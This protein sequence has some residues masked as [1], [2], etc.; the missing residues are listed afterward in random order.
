MEAINIFKNRRSCKSFKEEQ[1]KDEE[2]NLI[3]EAG[4][5]A[6]T[7]KDRQSPLIV[8]TQDKNII[9]KL[10]QENAKIMGV[11]NIDPFY[12][13]PTLVIVFYDSECSTGFEDACLVMGNM[14]NAAY[15]L[16]VGSCWIHRARQTFEGE[17]GLEL[18]QKWGIASKY[19]GV[20]NL[21]LGYAKSSLRKPSPRKENYILWR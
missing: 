15:T 11:E 9:K 17:Y 7:G 16:D 1:I 19:K 2:L 3:L 18:K 20:G 6:P 5:Y 13:A 12:G 10:S 4:T 14:M 8:V 21:I